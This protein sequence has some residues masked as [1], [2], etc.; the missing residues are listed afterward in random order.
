MVGCK[1]AKTSSLAIGFH[2]AAPDEPIACED[3]HTVVAVFSFVCG[4][5]DFEDLIELEQ[6]LNPRAI[7]QHG[8]EG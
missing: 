8:V 7:P 5:E 1:N 3:G 4:L 2:V 6:L